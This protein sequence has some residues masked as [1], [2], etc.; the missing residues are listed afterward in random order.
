MEKHNCVTLTPNNPYNGQFL[1]T[2][3]NKKA[4]GLVRPRQGFV[5]S[6]DFVCEELSSA[7]G[8]A[9]ACDKASGTNRILFFCEKVIYYAK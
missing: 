9:S 7:S 8:T 5:N 3:Q 6:F 2:T 1:S 4:L